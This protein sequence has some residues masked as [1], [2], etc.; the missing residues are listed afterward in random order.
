MSRGLGDVYKRQ[1]RDRAWL[2]INL[3]NLKWNV[4][5]IKRLLPEDCKFMAVVKANAYGHGSLEV[6]Q[7]LYKTGIRAF[8]VATL[9]EG[10]YLREN[11]IKGKILVL[12]Y[13]HPSNASYL[14]K[15]RLIQTVVDAEYAESLNE[16]GIPLKVHIGVDTGM[17]RLGE[18]YRN[19][20]KIAA[21]FD[22]KNLE[23]EGIYSH[24]CV[25]DGREEWAGAYTGKQIERFFG[26]VD[27]S[28]IHI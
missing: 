5:Q 19:R 1:E 20:E 18:D 14:A 27:L 23:V 28:L 4:E 21:I 10:I 13:T 26:V 24:L 6:A 22:C 2:E 25:S 15:Y 3:E 16:W 11:G 7:F 8:A 17:H 12:G 9:L